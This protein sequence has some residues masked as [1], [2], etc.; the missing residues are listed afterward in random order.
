[1]FGRTSI[2]WTFKVVGAGLFMSALAACSTVPKNNALFEPTGRVLK[3]T[4]V[5]GVFFNGTRELYRRQID[6][7]NVVYSAGSTPPVLG[8]CFYNIVV[9]IDEG[10]GQ[11]IEDFVE[12]R[13]PPTIT[14]V[15]PAGPFNR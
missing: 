5:V 4:P 2:S 6:A 3:T 13:C 8:R 15:T 9:D 1:M 14:G 11:L 10:R 7:V 12:R